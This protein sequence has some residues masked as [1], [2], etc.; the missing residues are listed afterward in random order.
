MEP[1]PSLEESVAEVMANLPAP[2]R[3][4]I[5]RGDARAA[6]A[7]IRN[8]YQLH[9]DAAGVVER[10]MLLLLAGLEPQSEFVASLAQE[11]QLDQETIERIV[12]DINVQIFVPLREQ[13]R[14]ATD[15]NP[16]ATSNPVPPASSGQQPTE[17]RPAGIPAGWTPPPAPSPRI[18]PPQQG[19][20]QFRPAA[21]QTIGRPASPMPSV[22]K[23]PAPVST[24]PPAPQFR[25][26]TH[27]APLPPKTTMPGAVPRPQAPGASAA[28]RP[29][30]PPPAN[31]PG[32]PVA[33]AA[34]KPEARPETPSPRPYSVDPYR[35]PLQ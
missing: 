34:A 30:P 31:L 5:A 29:A 28:L 27:V 2:I 8:K 15:L 13:I 14:I 12:N 10:E 23:P 24:M 35:E 9:V 18:T 16:S 25:P 32:A 17:Q 7:G 33:P 22:P 11:A 20:P 1:K 19:A 4:F 26:V 3:S 21:P 6:A